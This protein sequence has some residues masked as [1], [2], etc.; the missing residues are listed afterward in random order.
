MQLRESIY[1]TE[2]NCNTL[3]RQ[4]G[5]SNNEDNRLLC[6]E[7]KISDEVDYSNVWLKYDNNGMLYEFL[8]LRKA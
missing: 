7:R 8:E 5:I 1:L 2:T 3:Y 6:I 4:A